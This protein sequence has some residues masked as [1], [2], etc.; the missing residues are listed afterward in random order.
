LLWVEGVGVVVAGNPET[1]CI[2]MAI[3]IDDFEGGDEISGNIFYR[4]PTGFFS[5]CGGDFNFSNNLFVDVGTTIRQSAST[6]FNSVEQYARRIANAACL[7]DT[8][9][10]RV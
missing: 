10:P 4:V 2:R 5:N 7:V 9:Q 6:S 8:W 1:S 3:Y